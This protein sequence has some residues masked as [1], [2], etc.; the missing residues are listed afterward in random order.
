MPRVP[1]TPGG[2]R[3]R[4]PGRIWRYFFLHIQSF[5]F[6]TSFSPPCLNFLRF[7][8]AYISF[9][10][11]STPDFKFFTVFLH[12]YSIFHKAKLFLLVDTNEYDFMANVE[13]S[14]DDYHHHILAEIYI[15]LYLVEY[16]F[17]NVV[18]LFLSKS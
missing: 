12:S 17:L 8:H 9:S 14:R 13:W 18:I 1:P 2:Q 7:F 10:Q 3:A 4:L 15:Q 6:L 11:F 16:L 5:S